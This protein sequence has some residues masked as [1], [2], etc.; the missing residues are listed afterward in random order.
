MSGC[1]GEWGEVVRAAGFLQRERPQRP[2]QPRGGGGEDPG[3]LLLTTPL[4]GGRPQ[5]QVGSG[6]LMVCPTPS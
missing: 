5:C 4:A 6:L 1:P 2:S 3:G